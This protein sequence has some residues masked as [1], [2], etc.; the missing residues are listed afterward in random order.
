MNTYKTS[1]GERV[2]KSVIDKRIRDAKKKLLEN[3]VL[4]HGYNF[5]Q[6]CHVSSGVRLHCSHTLSVDRCQ[7]EGK[8]ELAWD[9]TNFR[10]LCH[11]CHAKYDKLI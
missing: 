10:V 6:E 9:I 8:A 7:K 11:Y 2:K 1:N 5:C 3:Q 4:E